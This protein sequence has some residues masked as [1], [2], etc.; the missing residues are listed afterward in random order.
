MDPVTSSIRVAVFIGPL[1]GRA[2]R[3][4]SAADDGPGGHW[5]ARSSRDGFSICSGLPLINGCPGLS[6]E[7]AGEIFVHQVQIVHGRQNSHTLGLKKVQQVNEFDLPALYPDFWVGF[8]EQQ[9]SRL[10]GQPQGNFDALPFASAELV[11]DAMAQAETSARSRARSTATRSLAS[12]P[13]SLP[14]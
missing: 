6:R 9:Q 10:L 5:K 13:R 4:Q 11:E 2:R 12:R 3:A 1:Y 7:Y 8:I 14:M